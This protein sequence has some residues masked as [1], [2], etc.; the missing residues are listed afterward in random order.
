[1][2]E[3]KNILANEIQEKVELQQGENRRILDG[4]YDQSLA[5]RCVNG[6]FVGR[7]TENIIA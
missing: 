5:V 1:M 4:H 7:K 6:T 2:G 3:T